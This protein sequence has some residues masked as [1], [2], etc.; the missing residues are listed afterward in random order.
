MEKNNLL[1]FICFENLTDEMKKPSEIWQKL[2]L[3]KYL[4][5]N[6]ITKGQIFGFC[7]LHFLSHAFQI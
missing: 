6:K 5:N 4:Y 7:L 2:L 1:K 3:G